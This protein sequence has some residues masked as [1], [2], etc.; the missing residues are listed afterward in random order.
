VKLGDPLNG[1]SAEAQV[2]NLDEAGEWLRKNAVR[3]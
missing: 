2:L 3:L 1:Y